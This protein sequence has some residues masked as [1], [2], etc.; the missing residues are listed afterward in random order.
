MCIIEVHVHLMSPTSTQWTTMMDNYDID[1]SMHAITNYIE[2]GDTIWHFIIFI[3]YCFFFYFAMKSYYWQWWSKFHQYQQSKQPPL[4]SYHLIQWN[5]K[6][7]RN[8]APG[9]RPTQKYDGVKPVNGIQAIQ[10]MIVGS[11]TTMQW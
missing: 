5:T 10:L 1:T 2:K 4:T 11:P 9:L 3:F 6:K 7:L 8:Q